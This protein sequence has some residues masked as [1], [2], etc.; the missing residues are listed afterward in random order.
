MKKFVGFYYRC[1]LKVCLCAFLSLIGLMVLSLPAFALQSGDF[2]YTVNR[3]STVTITQ[4]ACPSNNAEL[5]PTEAIIPDTIDGMPVVAIGDYAF[6]YCSRL[7]SVTIGNSVASIGQ[8]A[9][10]SCSGLTSVTIPA[11][12]TSIGSGAFG[13]CSSL[14]SIVVDVSNT[15]FSSQDG[16]LYNKAKTVLIQYPIGKSGGFT[17]PDSVTSIGNSAFY[18]CSGLTSVIIPNSVTSIGNNAFYKCSGLTGIVVDTNN[19]VFS[20]QDGVL[21]NKAKTVLIQYPIG[22]SGGFTI[23]NSVT[24]IGDFAYSF[25]S[26]LTSVT[27]PDSVTS[28][29]KFSFADCTDLTSVTIPNSV[30]IIG[31]QAFRD[32]AGLISVTIGNS[33][34]SIGIGVFIY[35][36]GLTRAYFLGNSP[37]MGTYVFYGC[38]SN[39]SI[40]YDSGSTGFTTPTWHGYPT[41]VCVP[42][43]VINLSSFTA[44]PKSGKIILEWSTESEIDNAGF[45]IYRSETE[46]G[47]YIK[48]NDSLISAQGFSTQ[49]ASYEFVDENVK[50]RK[51]YYYK[52]EDIDLS[53]K[54]TMHGEV[55]AMP[56]WIFGIG[57]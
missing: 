54:L 11:S 51:T 7:T 27:I 53:G 35:C 37:S 30:T 26:G 21:Y 13:N 2:T 41:S 40:C 29:G 57:K 28:I 45:N 52:L 4:Y 48:L 16:V 3:D 32:C 55:S 31:E 12:V 39:F 38:A 15:V 43:T 23:P 33:V 50:N 18:N 17:I 8:E 56:R 5:T 6:E 19:A 47:E 25:C 22:K 49:G 20:S 34:M 46:E 24:N 10:Y 9:F 42:P 14:T 1:I 44:T 36:S